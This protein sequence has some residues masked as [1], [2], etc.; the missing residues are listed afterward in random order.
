MEWDPR[1]SS[2]LVRSSASANP[3]QRKQGGTPRT[4]RELSR[5]YCAL[6]GAQMRSCTGKS[7]PVP[8]ARRP[9]SRKARKPFLSSDRGHDRDDPGIHQHNPSIPGI[10]PVSRVTDWFFWL[11]GPPSVESSSHLKP[12]AGGTLPMIT[13]VRALLGIR[14]GSDPRTGSSGP[15]PCPRSGPY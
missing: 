14:V 13:V 9:D 4:S 8:A 15:R 2:R 7:P 11:N 1:Q 12:V 5:M 3:R 10:P 6:H